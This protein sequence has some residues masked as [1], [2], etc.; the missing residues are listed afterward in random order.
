[1][2]VDNHCKL[3]QKPLSVL[4]SLLCSDTVKSNYTLL[5]QVATRLSAGRAQRVKPQIL[6]YLHGLE[7][8]QKTGITPSFYSI[9]KF[10]TIDQRCFDQVSVFVKRC[11]VRKVSLP[12][13]YSTIAWNCAVFEALPAL[14]A[15]LSFQLLCTLMKLSLK[16]ERI[17][18]HSLHSIKKSV[19]VPHT[20]HMILV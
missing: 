6:H 9:Q 10:S 5:G 8:Q 16:S 14:P 18:C 4:Q 2:Q 3:E 11:W 7:T 15:L 12:K 20:R 17:F 1:M 19:T 13:T